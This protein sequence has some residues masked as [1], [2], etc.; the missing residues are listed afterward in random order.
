VINI[1]PHRPTDAEVVAGWAAEALR[2][3][4]YDLGKALATIAQQAERHEDR[5]R[6]AGAVPVPFAGATRVEHPREAP[7]PRTMGRLSVINGAGPTGDG[8]ADLATLEAVARQ[9]MADPGATAIMARPAVLDDPGVPAPPQSRRC[10]AQV[11]RDG[12][13]DECHAVAYWSNDLQRWIHVDMGID[14]NHAPEI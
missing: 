10:R 1:P 8:D 2:D 12:V 13:A 5:I 7:D 3:G 9:A 6:R 4:R 14:A 11:T